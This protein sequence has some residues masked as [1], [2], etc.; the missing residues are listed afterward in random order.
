M[1]TSDKLREFE[2]R[3]R[4]RHQYYCENQTVDF[5]SDL[6]ALIR[7]DLIAYDKW[8]ATNYKQPCVNTADRNVD[9]YLKSREPKDGVNSSQKTEKK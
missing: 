8:C 5:L 3:W 2:E 4:L 6:T 7:D 9:E 1:T